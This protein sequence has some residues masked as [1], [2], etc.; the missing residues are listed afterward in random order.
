MDLLFMRQ[1]K[2]PDL[3]MV[4]PVPPTTLAT[5]L[6]IK[7]DLVPPVPERYATDS[8]KECVLNGVFEGLYDVNFNLSILL[9]EPDLKQ[10]LLESDS[11]EIPEFIW[12]KI[13]E[14][15]FKQL[16]WVIFSAMRFVHIRIALTIARWPDADTNGLEFYM[17]PLEMAGEEVFLDNLG[18]VKPFLKQLGLDKGQTQGACNGVDYPEVLKIFFNKRA[19]FF[20]VYQLNDEKALRHFIVGISDK[21]DYWPKE[22]TDVFRDSIK[23]NNVLDWLYN[24]ENFLSPKLH[25]QYYKG[26]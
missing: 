4:A 26:A 21:L 17:L 24:K 6:S 8:P 9:G 7:N 3:P 18:L 14:L 11:Y 15:D 19:Q 5:N 13:R 16:G 10:K 20:K 1:K 12:H 23:L 2:K 22:L 25:P